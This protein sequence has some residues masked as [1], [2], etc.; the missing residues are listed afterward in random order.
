MEGLEFQ[1]KVMLVMFLWCVALWIA[2]PLEEWLVSVIACV[3]L[4]IFS[5]S[6]TRDC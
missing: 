5:V 6:T 2:K 4:V 3:I 1:G